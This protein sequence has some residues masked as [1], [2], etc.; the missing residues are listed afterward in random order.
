M[1]WLKT[2]RGVLCCIGF[3]GMVL[4]SCAGTKAVNTAMV[5]DVDPLPLGSANM[6]FDKFFSSGLEQKPVS[7]VFDPR[8]DRVY[9]EFKYQTVTYRQYWDKTGR[10]GFIAAVKRYHAD[11]EARNLT[12]KPSK[13]RSAYGTLQS[14]TEWGQ[15]RFSVSSRASPR[16]ELGYH[17]KQNNP[18][19]TVLQREAKETHWGGDN[20]TSSLRIILYFTRIQADELA[21]FFDQDYLLSFLDEQG[22]SLASGTVASDEYN[23]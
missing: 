20:E 13:S 5:A 14:T 23:N 12:N 8:L 10:E 6:E 17:F 3:A 22:I 4:G 21:G 15:F 11:Y 7:L 18:Y 16:I 2:L 19:F 9:L 1:K